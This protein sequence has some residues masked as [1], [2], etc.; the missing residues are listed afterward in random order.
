RNRRLREVVLP[1][2][3]HAGAV[4]LDGLLERAAVD[5]VVVTVD[6]AGHRRN[7]DNRPVFNLLC[8]DDRKALEFTSVHVNSSSGGAP[9]RGKWPRCRLARSAPRPA[10]STNGP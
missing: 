10:E 7:A 1:E 9:C 2:V 4:L 5:D 8:Q 3:P 6:V